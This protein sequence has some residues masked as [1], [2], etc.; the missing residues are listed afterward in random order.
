[1]IITGRRSRR[2]AAGTAAIAAAA[3]GG[4]AI[5]VLA[6][7]TVVT[8]GTSLASGPPT[9]AAQ[10]PAA[11]GGRQVVDFTRGWKFALANPDGIEVPPAFAGA[12]LPAYDDSGWRS[13]DVPHDWSIELE[14]GAGP[15]TSAGTGFLRGGLGFYRKTFSLPP[16]AA[17]RRISLEFDGVYMNSEIYLNGELLGTHPYGYTG[18]AFDI[19][20]AVH[21]D[22]TPNVVAV[23]VQNQLPSSRWYSGSGIYRNVRLVVTGPIHVARSGTAVTTPDVAS[24]IGQGYADVRVATD[25]VNAGD[26]E[27]GTAIDVV[28]THRIRDE[29][30]RVVGTSSSTVSVAPGTARDTS[31][32]RVAS[33]ALWSVAAP[34]LYTLET[35]LSVEQREIDAVATTF[36]VR[37]VTLDPAQGLSVNGQYTKIRG[38]DLHHDLGA[39]GSAVHRDAIWRQM[40]IMK[41]MGVNALRTAHNPPAPELIDVCQRIG[42]V[43]MVEAFDT[44]RNNKTAFDYGDWFELE[45]PGT[46][47]LLWSDVDIAEMVHTFKNS[48]AV[49]MW[50]IGNEIRG[51]TVED[52]ERLVADI[53]AIDA[54]R[55]VVWGSDS[56]R[57]PPAP[58]SVNGRIAL[59]LDG[60]GLNY[61]TAQSVDALHALYPDTFWFESESSSSTSARGVYQWP[62]QLNTGEDY[63]PGQRLVS[64]YDNNMASW[65]MPAEYGLK[66]DRDRQFFTGE[67]LWSGI[68]YIG[69]PTP[70]FDQFPVK[71][72]FFGAVDTAGFPKDEFYAFASQWTTAPFVHLVPMNWTDHAPGDEVVVWAYASVDTV[73]L[74]LNGES[75]G[76]RRYDHKTTTFGAG[77]LETT[78]PTGDDKTFPSGSYTSPGGTSGKLHLTWSVPFAPGE[79]VAVATRDGAEVA[80]DTLRTAGKPRAL[81]LTPDRHVIAADGRSLAFVTVEVIDQHGVLVPSA[82]DAIHFAVSGGALAGVDSGRQESAESYQA[83]TRA[84][85]AGK[86]LAIIRSD[87]RPGPIVISASADGLLPASATVFDVRPAGHDD[88]GVV[89]PTVRARVGAQPALPETV[90]L[91]SRD[92]AI[93]HR[94][95]R[96][97]SVTPEQLASHEPYDVEG[98]LSGHGGDRADRVAAHVTP[99]AVEDVQSFA[100]AVPVGV[101]PFLP[102]EAR[103]TY[104]DGVT[105]LVDLAWDAV[106]P[107]ELD[108][109]GDFSLRG[110]L[111]GTELTTSLQIAVSDAY[112][113][114]ENLAPSASPSASFSGAPATLPASLNDGVTSG[115]TGWSNQYSKAATALLPAFNLA[116]PE[117]RVSLSWDAPQAVDTLVPF[118]R[119][120]AGR[121]FPAAVSVEYW[122]GRAFV[123]AAHQQVTWATGSEQPT[124]IQFDEV[125]TPE[126]RLV[127]TSAAPGT[128]DGFVQ[129]AELGALGHLP[130]P[131]LGSGGAGGSGGQGGPSQAPPDRAGAPIEGCS[132][133]GGSTSGALAALLAALAFLARPRSKPRWRVAERP[134]RSRSACARS[135]T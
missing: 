108:E 36:G 66:K 126:I 23:K 72:S 76:V 35:S 92:G 80:R 132:A 74:F 109:P 21:T 10:E 121:T 15:G 68:D 7:F 84:A 91:V 125:S 97:A 39:L 56:Y 24:T 34:H 112:S 60:V 133:S 13:L 42:I 79:L 27:R 52:A 75:L 87:E 65:T 117:D 127:M 134:P 26:D 41:Q 135:T 93:S 37:W 120:A 110:V 90:I 1:V 3:L 88:S 25:V 32:I 45:A 11:H 17:G 57:T 124:T 62:H 95:V 48:P 105:E 2:S 128:P 103:V 29:H 18:F 102:G 106:P 101:A 55:P 70:Y 16:A 50:S 38:V 4:A 31:T 100:T 119:L 115:E 104:T 43:V 130:S 82:D 113:P 96:W 111:S 78:E 5:A 83:D 14:P 54:T 28:V 59:L 107:G 19:S 69:E 6:L 73:E 99:F 129:I 77:Y 122:D 9:A 86:A 8:D 51:Q 12:H 33:P 94:P 85:H 30:G 58:D 114:G 20:G 22:G 118:F 61:N 98:T 46:G 123:P 44:W 63:T 116:Q 40:S 64:S 89:A 53:K 71:S 49:I 67:F 47:G 131:G 81:R